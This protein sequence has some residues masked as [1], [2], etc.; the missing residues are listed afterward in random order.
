MNLIGTF[1]EF[2]YRLES[3]AMAIFQY[4]YVPD[5]V[6]QGNFG[7]SAIPVSYK[8]YVYAGLQVYL[9]QGVVGVTA[10]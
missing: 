2:P 8:S 7:H 1:I 4:I 3:I 5:K 10:T 9:V 6:E